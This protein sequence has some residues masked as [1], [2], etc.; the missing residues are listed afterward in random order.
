MANL[1]DGEPEG[2]PQ[3]LW[4]HPTKTVTIDGGQARLMGKNHLDGDEYE[5]TDSQGIPLKGPGIA[6]V[7]LNP[8]SIRPVLVSGAHVT[9]TIVGTKGA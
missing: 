6:H 2:E 3:T 1:R 4:E 8:W 9:V 5:L 7:T